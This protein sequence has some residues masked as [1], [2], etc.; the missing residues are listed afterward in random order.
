MIRIVLTFS[1]KKFWN[2]KI[3]RLW[4]RIWFMHLE[5]GSKVSRLL[6]FFPT[7]VLKHRELVY[8]P[9]NKMGDCRR[10]SR[11]RYPPTKR[12]FP[13]FTITQTIAA[14]GFWFKFHTLPC[15]LFSVTWDL[16]LSKKPVVNLKRRPNITWMQ[17]II[18]P[19]AIISDFL[20]L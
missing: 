6:G 11:H 2:G 19:F 12:V 4:F 20:M 5:H 9:I 13:C 3:K 17:I 16:F 1:E 8:S 18:Y 15:I 10:S 14:L 7:F